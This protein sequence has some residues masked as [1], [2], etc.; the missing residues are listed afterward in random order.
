MIVYEPFFQEKK[1]GGGG[2]FH[3]SADDQQFYY[4][5]HLVMSVKLSLLTKAESSFFTLIIIKVIR[6][7]YKALSK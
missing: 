4:L 3:S 6:P 1:K 5:N 2:V 7:S